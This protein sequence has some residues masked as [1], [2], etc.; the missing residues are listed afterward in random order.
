MRYLSSSRKK[1][2]PLY[3][4]RAELSSILSNY[5]MRVATSEWRDYALDH[6]DNCAIFSIFKHAH[7]QPLFTIEKQHLKGT[8][9]AIF[10]LQDRKKTLIKTTKFPEL[11]SY[12]Q[13]MPR[14]V[15]A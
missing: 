2:K 9:K 13:R 4:S 10:I 12:L 7:E 6:I 8:E 3:F 14:L 5:A 15:S 1:S 11:I